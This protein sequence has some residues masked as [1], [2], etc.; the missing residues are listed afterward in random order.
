MDQ[1]GLLALAVFLLAVAFI[2]LGLLGDW[3]EEWLRPEDHARTSEP[4]MVAFDPAPRRFTRARS[5]RA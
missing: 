4:R 1:L 2:A 5:R 3:L